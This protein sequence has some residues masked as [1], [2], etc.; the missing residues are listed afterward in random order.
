[1]FCDL[2]DSTKLGQQLD[3]EDLSDVVSRY[4][5]E[6]S[7]LVERHGGHVA[8]FLGD[9]LLAYFG[10]PQASED[11][12]E[13]S[14]RAAL[15][16]LE[17]IARANDGIERDHQVRLEAR[18][19]IH[20]G[21]VVIGQVG[22]GT[23]RE[24]L[25][26]GDTTNIAARLEGSADPGSVFI[27]DATL[28]LVGGL[29]IA[30]DRGYPQLKGVS[31]RVRAYQILQR[32]GVRSRI[33]RSTRLTP[34]AGRKIETGLLLDRWEHAQ[35]GAGQI[36]R[37]VGEA[38]LGKSRL[39][40]VLRQSV[41]S[42]PHTWLE[43]RCSPHTQSSAL[44]PVIELVRRGLRIQEEDTGEVRLAKLEQG[45]ELAGLT[46]SSALAPL[47]ALD[48]I[49]LPAG[50]S[51]PAGPERAR[52]QTFNTL[53]SWTLALAKLQPLILVFEDLHWSDP[54][55]L[56]LLALLGARCSA[57]PILIV[58]TYRTSFEPSWPELEHATQVTL[59]RLGPRLAREMVESAS[60]VTAL[61]S[62][63]AERIVARA[64]GVP[65]FVEELTQMVLESGV[66]S[67]D[68]VPMTL[69]DSLMA[70]LDRLGP[71]K[72][73]AQRAAVLGREFSYAVLSAISSEAQEDLR[74]SL[75]RLVEAELLYPRGSGASASYVFK[76]ALVVDVA[77]Q[78]QLRR[79][80]QR[81]HQRIAAVLEQKFSA[82]VDADPALLAHHLDRAGDAAR[83]IDSYR[84]AAQRAGERS[85][86]AEAEQQLLRALELVSDLKEG[87]SRDRAELA[88]QN[89]LGIV[90]MRMRGYADESSV[91]AFER[92]AALALS[93][94]DTEA[95]VI[96][97]VGLSAHRQNRAEHAVA[98]E[99]AE[100]IVELGSQTQT[101][102]YRL[103]GHGLIS[104]PAFYMGELERALS[105]SRSALEYYE[106]ATASVFTSINDFGVAAHGFAAWSAT[107][108]GYPEQGIRCAAQAVEL[109][110]TIDHAFSTAFAYVFHAATYAIRDEPQPARHWAER[111]VEL[112]E[113]LHFP[114]W[115]GLGQAIEGWSQARDGNAD[116]TTAMQQGLAIAAGT[117][118]QAGAPLLL[119]LFAQVNLLNG[120][121]EEASRTVE[122]ALEL[123]SATG[124]HVADAFLLC[125]RG[126]AARAAGN[127]G[128]AEAAYH[129]AQEAA[130][131]T[132]ARLFELR[133]SL[134]LA[135]HTGKSG[136][137]KSDL[138]NCL[139]WFREGFDAPDLIE[140][141][142]RLDGTRSGPS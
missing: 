134:R 76:H 94:H 129:Q 133:A 56:E 141:R 37:V 81:L 80:R 118:S 138:A 38:G 17:G 3:P 39:L 128:P 16:I 31:S 84:R 78:S 46:P 64:D 20:T 85:A 55:T 120:N 63:M 47:A 66:E 10:Y 68:E 33:E 100:E 29:F 99:L 79:T 135:A 74:S 53:V 21:P 8:Q 44:Q 121:R 11:D 115:L 61:S 35:D 89:L 4:H 59:R 14:V 26:L 110:E 107:I 23:R 7:R 137:A 97:L 58:L 142:A 40:Q 22:G 127:N 45:I 114:L 43:A 30:R 92:A 60:G 57:A 73:V 96:A 91:P 6:A 98:I 101:P 136:S 132:G 27:S 95:R 9:G 106:G 93:Q 139:D 51:I 71:A 67:E 108:L 113:E 34:M 125:L 87:E 122:Q 119:A 24:R 83:A 65:L 2:V 42:T 86:N 50:V 116:G 49:P 32:S 117:G 72:E 131:A 130:R 124:Q 126:D 88:L 12:G 48:G 36:V 104:P 70:R 111:A 123:A 77:Y 82:R 112:S 52:Q 18:I 15:E 105:E 41:G 62:Q 5:N 103:S 90:S 19:G 28:A 102:L 13:N 69:Q 109:A 54:S 140:A 75:E 25:A 1:M